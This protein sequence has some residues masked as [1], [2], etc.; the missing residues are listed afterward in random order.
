MYTLYRLQAVPLSFNHSTKFNNI[1]VAWS[2]V[3]TSPDK[4]ENYSPAHQCFLFVW[5]H[6][7]HPVAS[8]RPWRPPHQGASLGQDQSQPLSS[9]ALT[10]Q[11]R[12]NKL[13]MQEYLTGQCIYTFMHCICMCDW[14]HRGIFQWLSGSYWQNIFWWTLTIIITG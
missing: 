8:S 7:L 12:S 1:D 9:L 2:F 4:V 5:C 13:I 3:D 14:S 6:S 10:F 11:S